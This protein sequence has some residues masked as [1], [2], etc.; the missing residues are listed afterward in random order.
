M[1]GPQLA[2]AEQ[3]G[4]EPDGRLEHDG[5][6]IRGA[7]GSGSKDAELAGV[8]PAVVDEGWIGGRGD[9]ERAGGVGACGHAARKGSV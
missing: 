4:P 9:G 5:R 1:A 6:W 8:R 3:R 7:G 2:A